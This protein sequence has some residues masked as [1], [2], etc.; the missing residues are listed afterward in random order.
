MELGGRRGRLRIGAAVPPG[1]WA[2]SEGPQGSLQ[3]AGGLGL[4]E[5]PRQGSRYL[6]VCY[7][8]LL[9]LLLSYANTGLPI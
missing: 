6:C 3:G 1:A 8:L 7:L 2:G 9:E 4:G 5:D